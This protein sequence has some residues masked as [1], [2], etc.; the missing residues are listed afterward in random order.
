MALF[1]KKKGARRRRHRLLGRQGRGAEGR[2]QGRRRVPAREHRHGAASSRGDRRRRDH[3]LRRGDRR[4]PARSSS[5]QKIKT[6][7]RGH[8]RV[9]QRRHRQEDQPPPDEP[10]GAG[11]VDPLGGRAVHPLRHPG[12]L[13][14]LRGDRGRRA[15]GNMD[16]LLVAVKKDKISDYTSAISQAGKNAADRGRGRVRPPEL[17]RDQL[18]RRPRPGGR[19]AERRGLDHE[20]QH[21]QGRH[22]DLQ[23]RHRRGR[24]PVHGRDPEGPEPVLRAGRGAQEGRAGGR[25]GPREPAPRS[26]RPSPRTSPSRSRRRSTSSRPRARRTG[27]TGS[28][29]S[30]GT[31]RSRACGTSSPTASRRGWRS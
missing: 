28:S 3:G 6:A 16:V 4:H 19:A 20:H 5:A 15:A 12:R 1:G 13:A 7:R 2:R 25:G 22:L 26:S 18:R 21:R 29:S 10:G 30:G 31:R 17:L 11:G 8:E 27:S 24:Q 9:R 23:P 14:R